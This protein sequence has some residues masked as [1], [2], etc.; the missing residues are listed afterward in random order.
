MFRFPRTGEQDGEWKKFKSF[1][2]EKPHATYSKYVSQCIKDEINEIASKLCEDREKNGFNTINN[3]N[4]LDPP[5]TE[6]NA[7]Q[8]E[9]YSRFYKTPK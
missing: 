8:F 4:N 7:R 2:N 1:E 9:E 5:N 3:K 6:S